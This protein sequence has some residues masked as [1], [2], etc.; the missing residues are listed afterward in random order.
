MSGIIRGQVTVPSGTTVK[1]L[2]E[3]ELLRT[4]KRHSSV[5]FLA[6]QKVVAGSLLTV[7][8][9]LGNAIAG[10]DLTPNVASADGVVD[11]QRDGFPPAMGAPLDEIQLRVKETTAGAGADGVLYYAIEISDLA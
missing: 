5:R 11:K 4:L 3:G 9:N 10:Q 7:D 8:W 6:T 1:N 2:L